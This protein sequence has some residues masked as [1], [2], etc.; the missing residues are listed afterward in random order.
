MDRLQ[1]EWKD[2]VGAFIKD[3]RQRRGQDM[4]E[5]A[6]H[7]ADAELQSIIFWQAIETGKQTRDIADY[8]KAL[9]NFGRLLEL[10]A[11]RDERERKTYRRL[12]ENP[13][14]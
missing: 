4:Q 11:T 10:N 2:A 1:K 13:P 14:V 5:I 8:H 3:T 12:L 9:R 6:S 7:M